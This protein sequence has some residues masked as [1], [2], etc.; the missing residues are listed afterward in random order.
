MPDLHDPTLLAVLQNRATAHQARGAA[1][2]LR[3]KIAR[4]SMPETLPEPGDTEPSLP[5]LLRLAEAALNEA[6][7]NGRNQ[8]RVA[9]AGSVMV[10][11]STLPAPLSTLPLGAERRP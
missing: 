3:R 4:R 1:E 7:R 10:P 9:R 8:V 6:K 2:R 11:E 5:E